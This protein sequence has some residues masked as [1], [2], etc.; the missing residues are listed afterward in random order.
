MFEIIHIPIMEEGAAVLKPVPAL[1]L[2]DQLFVVQGAELHRVRSVEVWE[3]PPG[4]L[5]FVEE[6]ELSGGKRMVAVR[7]CYSPVRH[8]L[9]PHFKRLEVLLLSARSKLE[10]VILRISSSLDLELIDEFIDVGE[11]GLAYE[12]LVE[13]FS[14]LHVELPHELIVA[15]QLMKRGAV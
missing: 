2:R 4:T 15:G 3:Y 12:G 11:Y 6:Q 13:V 7:S 1:R 5:V 14:D 8:D 10:I 9:I